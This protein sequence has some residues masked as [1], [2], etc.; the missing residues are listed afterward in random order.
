MGFTVIWIEMVV[1]YGAK[2]CYSD[3]FVY[4]CKFQN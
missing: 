3:F 2:L 4:L 1:F